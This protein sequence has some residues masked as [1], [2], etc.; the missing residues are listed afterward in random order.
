M[1][2]AAVEAS[3][4]AGQRLRGHGEGGAIIHDVEHHAELFCLLCLHRA[5]GEDQ[6]LGLLQADARQ[7][8]QHAQVGH[9]ADAAEHG[10]ELARRVAS[11]KSAASARLRPAPKAG[12]STAAMTGFSMFTSS[13]SHWCS[14][15][16]LFEDQAGA[17]AV[18]HAG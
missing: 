11:T 15:R 5:R 3:P 2:M 17:R 10:A 18:E 1:P 6:L 16:I 4:S 13:G 7:Q 12:P 14:S 8:V 9:Q